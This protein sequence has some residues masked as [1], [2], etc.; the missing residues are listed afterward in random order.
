[1]KRKF[2][3]I[4]IFSMKKQEKFIQRL[5]L[6]VSWNLIWLQSYKGLKK[7][8]AWRFVT[9]SEGNGNRMHKCNV[10]K[11]RN[12]KSEAIQILPTDIF[13][14][15]SIVYWQNWVV[16]KSRLAPRPFLRFHDR[17][18]GPVIINLMITIFSEVVYIQLVLS[19][20]KFSLD[21]DKWW[22]SCSPW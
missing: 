15:Y 12:Y 4:L 20:L 17:G 11:L 7:S 1:M 3:N 14:K 2:F 13:R 19:I 9:S 10:L 6:T 22:L 16:K 8:T 21:S 18:P 5:M